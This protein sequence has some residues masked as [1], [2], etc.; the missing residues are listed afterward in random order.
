MNRSVRDCARSDLGVELV[1][2]RPVRRSLPVRALMLLV[3]L[4]LS[5]P[6]LA[7]PV[8]RIEIRSAWGGL[9]LS[10]DERIVVTRQGDRFREGRRGIEPS[11]IDALVVAL[12]ASRVS[13]VRAEN[14]GISPDWLRSQLADRKGRAQFIL[15]TGTPAQ[16]DF[17]TR[18]LAD[19]DRIQRVIPTLFSGTTLDNY[20]SAWVDVTLNDGSHIRAESHS[21]HHFMLPW[22]IGGGDRKTY[23]ADISRALTALLPRGAVN[24]PLLSGDGLADDLVDGVKR[25]FDSEWNMA[26]ARDLAGDALDVLSRRYD[27]VS[28]EVHS[29]H[30]PEYGTAT[31]KGEPKET[32]LHV[33]L[34]KASLPPNVR[35][36]LVLAQVAGKIVGTEA[37]LSKVERYEDAVMKLSWLRT[38]IEANPLIPI[39]ISFVHDRSFGDKALRTYAADMQLRGRPDLIAEARANQDDVVLLIVGSFFNPGAYWLLFPDNRMVMWRFTGLNGFLN[40]QASDFTRG[41]CA[42]YE[43]PSGGC[44]D[45]QVSPGGA[46]LPDNTSTRLLSCLARGIPAGAPADDEPL[47]PVMD[48]G[49]GG[50]IDRRGRV[51]IPLCFDKVGAFS[52]GLARFE[53]D[54]RW[55]YTDR[56]GR[57]VIQPTFEWAQEFSEGRAHVQITGSSLGASTW[58]Y[59]DRLGVRVGDARPGGLLG[60]GGQSNIGRDS[61]ERALRDGRALVAVESTEPFDTKYGYVDA[62]GDLAIPMDFTG[63]RPFSDG[64]AAAT[65]APVDEA[66]WGFIDTGGRWVIPPRFRW[67]RQF[68]DGVAGAES[69]DGC[70]YV[71]RR[72]EV[73]LRPTIGTRVEDCVA[74]FGD[75]ADGLASV[76]VGKKVGFMDRSGQIVVKPRFEA[77]EPFSEGL[78]AVRTGEKWGFIDKK[79]RMIIRPRALMSAESFRNGLAFVQTTDGRYGY[80]DTTG[81]YVWTPTLLYPE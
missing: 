60:L 72:G 35:V 44:S 11:A 37:F 15:R 70:I 18:T 73:V 24:R 75:F 29:F 67:P 17:F 3:A 53:S 51:V 42:E 31:Y 32:N 50:F 74:T 69:T 54:G 9:G 57:I 40:W 45:R 6:G 46:L 61:T 41:Q 8:S 52:E 7:Q 10:R 55:G 80:I 33:A 62:R 68:S 2:N 63:A 4:A 21:S 58:V 30:H 49:R 26:G 48:R 25:L 76:R 1:D 28:A 43:T 5:E 66:G 71:N 38:F 59:V 64:L 65:Q 12:R 47:F 36:A 39:Q 79:G 19:A 81:R 78:A 14:L 23:N 77:V 16:R 20:P 56:A 27:I 34:R 22:I 13:E